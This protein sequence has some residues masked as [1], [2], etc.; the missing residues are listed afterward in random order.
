[1]AGLRVARELGWWFPPSKQNPYSI[2]GLRAEGLRRVFA[3][4]APAAF[5]ALGIRRV[6][7]QGCVA[8]CGEQAESKGKRGGPR[9]ECPQRLCTLHGE[10]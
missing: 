6:K 7:A 10:R 8:G 3:V 1:M 2:C 9:T 5:T 4:V